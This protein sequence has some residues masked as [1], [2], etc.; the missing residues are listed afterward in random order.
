M[1]QTAAKPTPGVLVAAI[2]RISRVDVTAKEEEK[3]VEPSTTML[4][5]RPENSTVFEAPLVALNE[6]KSQ[7]EFPPVFH[8]ST[9]MAD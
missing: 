7:G 2:E 8:P 3:S 1:W 9:S 5:L 4:V 6:T